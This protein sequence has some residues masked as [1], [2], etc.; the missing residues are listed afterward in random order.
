MEVRGRH[1]QPRCSIPS[2][3]RADAGAGQAGDRVGELPLGD[4]V[5]DLSATRTAAR[6]LPWRTAGALL[7]AGGERAGP[8]TPMCLASASRPL[9]AHKRASRSRVATCPLGTRQGSLPALNAERC[10]GQERAPRRREFSSWQERASWRRPPRALQVVQV[11]HL[12]RL[13]G[14]A[15][16]GPVNNDSDGACHTSRH[17]V[18]RP[19]VLGG[20]HRDRAPSIASREEQ[21]GVSRDR[22]GTEPS[23][24]ISWSEPAAPGSRLAQARV[25]SERDAVRPGR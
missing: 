15:R 13:R 3:T 11:S 14:D 9:P 24:P 23:S 6:G 1:L 4:D 17:C 18:P 10:I 22:R 12:T 5:G 25:P 19:S 8:G 21:K 2:L 20:V 16:L 7:G